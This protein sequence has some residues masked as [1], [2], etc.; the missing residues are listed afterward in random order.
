MNTVKSK[1]KESNQAV[2]YKVTG[3]PNK[4][5]FEVRV[6]I[7]TIIAVMLLLYGWSWLKSF[8]PLHPPQYIT[9]QFR[10]IA[11]LANNAPVNISG[12]RVGT[13]EKIDL[14][15][16]GQVLAHLKIKTEE[17]TVPQGSNFTIQTLG[18]VG[19][20]YIEITLPEEN[21]G[22]QPRPPIDSNTVVIGQDPIRVELVIN[23]IATNVNNMIGRVSDDNTQSSFAS[24]IQRSGE[25][26]DNINA[27]ATKLNKNMDNISTATDSLVKTSKKFG[28]VADSAKNLTSSAN[29]FFK[30]GEGTMANISSLTQD[31]KTTSKRVNKLLDSPQVV[32]DLRQ[33]AKDAKETVTA[34]R[35]VMAELE[36]T[37][38]DKN[39]RKDLIALLKQI[40]QSTE[41]IS[42]SM[43]S[44]NKMTGDKELRGD[45][46][47]VVNKA[48]DAVNRVD[49][50]INGPDFKTDLRSTMSEVHDAAKHIDLAAKQL[51]QILDKRAPLLHMMIGRPGKLPAKDAQKSAKSNTNKTSE[52]P[53]K[54]RQ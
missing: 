28:E 30:T 26:I 45:I 13:V 33:T 19:A 18:L 25:T 6:G 49:K 48:H 34:V 42:E 14:K 22:G 4:P 31:F 2:V 1:G 41:N 23:K 46:K 44:L 29:S 36:T 40:T 38:K 53:V 5:N 32:G 16:R 15:G 52:N 39:L 54:Q 7:F 24:A 9:V 51:N 12:V 20:K 21:E 37:L 8:S 35:Q 47:V 43:T 11:G 27:A 3:N 50:I 10:D 17:V